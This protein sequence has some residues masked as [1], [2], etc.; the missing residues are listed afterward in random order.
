MNDDV[1]SSTSG[2]VGGG[3]AMSLMALGKTALSLAVVVGVILLCAWLL[4][5]MGPNR[6]AGSQHLRVVASTPVGQRERVVI[7]EVE[8]RWL[9][10]GVGGGQVTKLDSL[11]PP[12]GPP[13]S[14]IGEPPLAGSFSQR[15]RQAMKHN[16]TASRGTRTAPAE[17]DD[18]SQ[19][20]PP[21]GDA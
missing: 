7:V 10:L 1:T 11:A 16:L 17:R 2:M 14:H 6:R 20:R 8:D 4:K 9:V 19:T 13:A 18:S 5:R 21:K 3:D 12:V 15:L